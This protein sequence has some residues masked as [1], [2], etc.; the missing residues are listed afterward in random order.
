MYSGGLKLNTVGKRLWEASSEQ[1]LF[2]R[3]TGVMPGQEKMRENKKM[4]KTETKIEHFGAVGSNLNKQER[5][6]G[7]RF[8]W[9]FLPTTFALVVFVAFPH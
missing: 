9:G 4:L 5:K 3:P 6:W 7:G 8:D 1:M 2:I